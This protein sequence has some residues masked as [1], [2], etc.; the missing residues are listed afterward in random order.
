MLRNDFTILSK[1]KPPTFSVLAVLVLAV[2]WQT[3]CISIFF[4]YQT[5]HPHSL[6][7]NLK[8]WLTGG[9]NH[10]FP[11][12][13]I[14]NHPNSLSLNV[15]YWLCDGKHLDFRR[16]SCYPASHLNS[17]SLQMFVFSK[18]FSI[19]YLRLV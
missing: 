3:S 15:K 17:S 10:A 2:W 18:G 14:P 4:T 13:H 7:L 1:I 16:D 12:F 11:F 19:Y 9:K 6:P 5:T 8:Y